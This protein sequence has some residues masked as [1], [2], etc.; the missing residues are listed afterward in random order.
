MR[1]RELPFPLT[2]LLT[3]Y[4]IAVALAPD[5]ALRM[6]STTGAPCLHKNADDEYIPTRYMQRRKYCHTSGHEWSKL[7]AKEI[8]KGSTNIHL[9]TTDKF[10]N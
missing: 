3:S 5:S 7:F 9:I 10:G 1:P 6:S 4:G 8:T 2:K